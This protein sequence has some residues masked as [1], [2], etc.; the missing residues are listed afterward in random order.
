MYVYASLFLKHAY[1]DALENWPSMLK[2]VPWISPS[3]PF[4]ISFILN[5]SLD[6]IYGTVDQLLNQN[7]AL[8]K[9]NPDSEPIS[10]RAVKCS[11]YW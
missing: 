7:I 6:V 5:N 4:V 11:T 1:L 8:E 3:I 2:K 10:A 9:S